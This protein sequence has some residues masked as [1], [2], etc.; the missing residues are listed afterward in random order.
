MPTNQETAANLIQTLVRAIELSELAHD[1]GPEHL[2]ITLHRNYNEGQ[3]HLRIECDGTAVELDP[4]HQR[5]VPLFGSL[6]I[7]KRHDAM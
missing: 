7:E 3:A 2:T 4:D 5:L 6:K 1:Y